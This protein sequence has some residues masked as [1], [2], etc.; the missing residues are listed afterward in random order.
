MNTF[1]AFPSLAALRHQELIEERRVD[2][3]RTAWRRRDRA[4]RPN[5]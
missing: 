4:E 3:R 5:R 2:H 1:F